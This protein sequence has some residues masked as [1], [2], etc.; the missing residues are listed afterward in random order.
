MNSIELRKKIKKRKPN[1]IRQDAHKK[2]RLKKKWR[3]AKGL[4]SK[5]RLNKRGY[6]I[7]IRK[8]YGSPKDA[9]NLYPE[10]IKRNLIPIIRHIND[11]WEDIEHLNNL[12]HIANSN[13]C[14]KKF[15]NEKRMIL[16]SLRVL[17]IDFY[18]HLEIIRQLIKLL[19]I[20]SSSLELKSL[21]NEYKK[22]WNKIRNIRHHIGIHKERER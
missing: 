21:Y 6:K 20:E 12:F 19:M 2:L 22:Y 8:G 4:H 17:G 3:R 13:L 11:S 5:I 1:F 16:C 15:F 14:E 18:I 10:G 7:A 9:H